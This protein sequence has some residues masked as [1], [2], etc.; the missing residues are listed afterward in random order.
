MA[1]KEKLDNE[2]PQTLEGVVVENVGDVRGGEGDGGGG[3]AFTT[4]VAIPEAP[5]P[6]VN[7]DD[8]IKAACERAAGGTGGGA[9]SGRGG[10]GGGGGKDKTSPGRNESSDWLAKLAEADARLSAAVA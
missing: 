10:G 4:V 8:A 5:P 6:P 7:P 9:G 1:E 2:E 3:G